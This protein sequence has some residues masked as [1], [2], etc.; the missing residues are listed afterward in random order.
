MKVRSAYQQD[1]LEMKGQKRKIVAILLKLQHEQNFYCKWVIDKHAYMCNLQVCA[2]L[3]GLMRKDLHIYA[4]LAV[5]IA[6]VAG[7]ELHVI[8]QNN[9]ALPNNWN[10]KQ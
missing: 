2:A 7:K 3:K 6:C 10:N 9:T 8:L 4:I 1:I 5:D